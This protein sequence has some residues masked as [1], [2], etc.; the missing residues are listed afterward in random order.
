MSKAKNYLKVL[1]HFLVII[2][3]G[4][5]F[6]LGFFYIFL[7]SYTNHQETLTVPNLEGIHL[8]QVDE[9]LTARNLR[10]E[11]TSDSSFSSAHPP[12]T[13]LKQD[14]RAGSKV[15]ENRKIYISLNAANPPSVKMPRL[16]DGSV[17]NAMMV[18]E[19]LGL[20]LGEIEYVPDLAQ[21]AVLEQQFN[22]KEIPEGTLIPKGSRI[23]LVVGDGLGNQVL[24]VPDVVGMDIEDAEVIIKGSGLKIGALINEAGTGQPPGT[25][26]R[27]TPSA[28]LNIRIGE[29]IDLWIVD[30]ANNVFEEDA[31]IL[32][33]LEN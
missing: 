22:G 30:P 23:D 16:Q 32:Q 21:N 14:P 31:P 9:Y 33:E 7:P 6:L 15:K 8:D 18:L 10:Y 20:V 2:T 25:V 3:L 29:V 12:H 26:L 5:F 27:Q 28:G 17:K 24:T 11:V 1:I 4:L 13:I 19:S